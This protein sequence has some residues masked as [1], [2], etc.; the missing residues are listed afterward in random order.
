MGQ[1]AEGGLNVHQQH[2]QIQRTP[3]KHTY[4][5][6][7]NKEVERRLTALDRDWLTIWLTIKL[8]LTIKVTVNCPRITIALIVIV[9]PR[10]IPRFLLNNRR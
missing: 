5:S 8:W 7:M 3:D 2:P 6:M 10:E 4:P 1:R 9:I